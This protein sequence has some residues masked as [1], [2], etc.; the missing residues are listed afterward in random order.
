MPSA[1]IGSATGNFQPGRPAAFT[2][3]AIVLHRTGGA[4]DSL[5]ARFND[6]TASQSAHYVVCRD[7][8]V[9]QYVQERDTAFHAGMMI[10]ATWPRLRPKVNPNFYTIGIELEG[11]ESDDWPEPQVAAAAMLI[12]E[13]ARRWKIAVDADHVIPHSAIRSSSEC[14]AASCPLARI[15]E[16]ARGTPAAA[17][18]PRQAVVRTLTRTNLRRGNPSL[19]SPIVRVLPPDTDV[20]AAEFTDAGERVGGNPFWY[21]D[22]EDG[23]FWAGATDVP[24]P[25]DDTLLPQINA[26]SATTDAMELSAAPAPSPPPAGNTGLAIDRTT[27]AL[28]AK[29]FFAEVTRKDL[30][31]L[32][33]TAGRSARSAFD[34]WRNDPRHIATA[35]IVDVDGT[36]YEV[37]PPSFWASHLGVGGTKNLHDR[38][39]IG[40][41][42]VNVGPLQQSTDDPAILNWWPPKS[43]GASEFTTRFCGLDESGRYVAADYRGK[44]HFASFPEVQVDAVGA[45]VRAMC[46]QFAIPATLPSLD[47]RFD[48]DV[49]AFAT[50]QGVCTHANFRLDKW[51]IGP[52]FPWDRLAL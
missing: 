6:P 9:D 33:F 42:I 27:L 44:S 49:S 26:N 46:E 2:P 31:V 28:A 13:V 14:P 22:G 18:V 52:A 51:D 15:I 10:A 4:R 36:I 1:F 5:R 40:I 32:H 30:V 12:A 48:C 41:E 34:T 39:S 19:E 45:L 37:F 7:G 17:R 43:Q 11:A 3:E 21:G 23:Y 8:R 25:T 38:R 50:Y 35:Y 20:I 29:E 47:R 24:N 16:L